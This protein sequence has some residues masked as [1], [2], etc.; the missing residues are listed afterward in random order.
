[1]K[2]LSKLVEMYFLEHCKHLVSVNTQVNKIYNKEFFIHFN[3]QF[4][5]VSIELI[6][7]MLI[8]LNIET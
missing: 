6:D 1:M 2:C 8:G 5:H 3:A 4:L 7:I